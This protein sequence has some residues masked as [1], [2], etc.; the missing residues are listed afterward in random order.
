MRIGDPP[1]SKSVSG[2]CLPRDPADRW[3]CRRATA[4][5]IIAAGIM[6]A[7]AAAALPSSFLG[8]PPWLETPKGW[9]AVLAPPDEPGGRFIMEGRLLGPGG[10]TGMPG[11][12]LFVYHADRDGKYA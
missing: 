1:L 11:V 8:T 4:V 10:K 5:L 12:K 6:G 9:E 3:A 7:S 2:G